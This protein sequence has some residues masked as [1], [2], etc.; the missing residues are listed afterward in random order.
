MSLLQVNDVTAGYQIGIDILNDL[1]LQ[2]QP[3]SVTIIIGPRNFIV[4]VI[5]LQLWQFTIKYRLRCAE[6]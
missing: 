3:G 2:V 4:P 1:S 5:L 6:S